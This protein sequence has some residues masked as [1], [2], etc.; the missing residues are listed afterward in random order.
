MKII[1]I[2]LLIMVCLMGFSFGLDYLQGYDLN[3]TIRNAVSPFQVMD[4]AEVIVLFSFVLT[5]MGELFHYF[6]KK[7]KGNLIPNKKR[8]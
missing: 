6:Y 5:I 8:A 3:T 2:S 7:R 1:G 4:A